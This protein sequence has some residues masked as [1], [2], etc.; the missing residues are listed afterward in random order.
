MNHFASENNTLLFIAEIGGN[1]EGDFAYAEHL[2]QLAIDSGAD[3]VKFQIYAGDSLVSRVEGAARNAHFKKFE[4]GREK[5]EHLAEMCRKAGVMFM[6]S[7]WDADRLAW[8]DKLIPIHKVGSGDFTCFPLIKKLV[9]SDKPL[10]LSTGLCT[11]AEVRR[12]IEYVRSLDPTYITGHKLALLQC[13]TS[14]PCP[15]QDANLRAMT[16]LKEAFGLPTGYSDH[17]LGMD[18]VIAAATMGAEIIEAHFTDSRDNKT[19]R[20]HLVSLTRDEVREFLDLTRK[21][22][23]LQGQALKVPTESEVS[24]GHIPQFR[25]AV[26]AAKDIARGEVFS[27]D[28]LTVLRPEHGIPAH[29]FDEALGRKAA[30]DIAFHQAIQEDDLS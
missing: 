8:A 5:Y 26:Y 19:F 22:K 2:A 15:D 30:R 23:T 3:A 25:R 13:T 18:A 14:Y 1:H 7:V 6:A 9:A 29:R 20:D 16:M 4:L 11:L 24:S 10:I 17:T 28:N 21:I 27:E 12:T